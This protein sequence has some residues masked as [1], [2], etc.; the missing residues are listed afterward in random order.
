[1]VADPAHRRTRV[2]ATLEA[3]YSRGT[4]PD[5]SGRQL[6]LE[7]HS[8]RQDIGD[9]IR[10]L[11]LME[12]AR[13]TLEVGLAQGLSTLF[14]CDALLATG[15]DSVTHVAM[16][17]LQRDYFGNAGLVTLE[18]AGVQDLVEFHAEESQ[19]VLPRLAQEG[20]EV[21]LA[22]VD[23]D[24]RFDGV[25]VDAYY[26]C[27]LVRPGGLL[28]LDDGWLRA[29]SLTASYLVTNLGFELLRPG[30]GPEYFR[31][32]RSWRRLGRRGGFGQLAVLRAP[33]PAPD[34]SDWTRFADFT[35]G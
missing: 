5:E 8:V 28:I 15:A 11:A 24:H 32:R 1:M 27:R 23:G 35:K 30:D 14:L 25:F 20:Y 34:R 6:A 22:F 3:M 33:D 21:D 31:W 17:P 13:R 26:C 19:L 12:G 10:D 29:T 18:R 7:P 4:S 16:D 2:R 9:A